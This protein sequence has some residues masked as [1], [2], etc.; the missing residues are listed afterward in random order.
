MATS[1]GLWLGW[2]RRGYRD[3]GG[4]RWA[5]PLLTPDPNAPYPFFRAEICRVAKRGSGL[6]DLL[7]GVNRVLL[8]LVGLL[9]GLNWG[10][11]KQKTRQQGHRASGIKDN[12]V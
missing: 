5:G 12:Y 9:T 4:Y 10:M 1:V 6:V 3:G 8:R 11:G 2:F 7:I